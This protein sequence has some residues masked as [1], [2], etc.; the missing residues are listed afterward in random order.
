MSAMGRRLTLLL[1]LLL[2]CIVALPG[3]AQGLRVMTFN[4]R[5]PTDADGDNRWALRR[6]QVAR[7]LAAQQP[8]VVGTQELYAEQGDYLAAQLPG[9]A[10]FGQGRRGGP[11]DEHVGVLYRHDRLRVL[12]SGD[13]WLSDTPEVAGSISWRH[14]YPRLV[15]WALFQ[16]KADGRRFYLFN[17]HLP[18]RDEDQQARLRGVRLLRDRISALP[19]EVP[20]VVTGDFN[21]APDD[22]VHATLVPPLR[23]AWLAAPRTQGPAETFHGFTGRADRRIDWILVRGLAVTHAASLDDHVDGRYPSDH[24]PVVADL[25]WDVAATP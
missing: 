13:F 7:L 1:G 3:A 2:G 6:E 5:L 19:A 21:I 17:T 10:W 20:V 8:D 24:F 11:G 12:A 9:Y 15:T 23:D 16:L 22:T 25:E 4:V 18:Y 14:L